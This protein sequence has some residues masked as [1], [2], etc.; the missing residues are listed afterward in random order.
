MLA[1]TTF[2][3]GGERASKLD[4]TCVPDSGFVARGPVA[5]QRHRPRD[6]F[7]WHFTHK[8]NLQSITG[9]GCLLPSSRA[10]PQRSVA[11]EEV[12]SRRTYQ[13]R[14]DPS[15]PLSTVREHVPFYIAAKSP[16]LYVVTRPGPES[17]RTQSSDL[18]FMGLTLGDIVDAGLTW[19]VSN[20]N[21]SS[22][23]TQ[24]SHDLVQMGGFVDF[25]LLCQRMWSET[26]EDPFRPGRRAAECLVL[27]RVPLN[28]VSVIVTR[29]TGGLG[30]PKRLF[31]NVGGVRQY[32]AMREIFYY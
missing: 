6:W 8:D 22:R 32:R 7:V 1:P 29:D 30:L 31:E 25:D 10:T 27:G 2:D 15:Y 12:K 5:P 28:L 16:M 4:I 11:N 14:P 19:C 21:A 26:Q 18:V 20:G 17:Y 13:V 23:Y 3:G 24:F 9:D